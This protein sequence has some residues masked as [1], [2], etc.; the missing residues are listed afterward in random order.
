[1]TEKN[2]LE[3]PT[4]RPEEVRREI[5]RI[6]KEEAQKVVYLDHAIDRKIQRE[7]TDI[8]ILRV[9][10]SG[11]QIGKVTWCTEKEKGYRCKLEGVSAGVKVSVIA[12]L[13]TI[14]ERR[15]LVVSTWTD[16]RS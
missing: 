12:K 5:A 1:M 11:H 3:F 9:L 16:G 8:Q 6:A 14:N 13:V 4:I 15:C 7:I 2:L 10:K